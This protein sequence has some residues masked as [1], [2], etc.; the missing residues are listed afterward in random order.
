MAD[1]V[2]NGSFFNLAG[3]GN[4]IT[5]VTDAYKTQTLAEDQVRAAEEQESAFLLQSAQAVNQ[6]VKQE[7]VT[8][9]QLQQRQKQINDMSMGKPLSLIHI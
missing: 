4:L 2:D 7:A 8:Q 9:L 5:G 3:L 6:V 1:P